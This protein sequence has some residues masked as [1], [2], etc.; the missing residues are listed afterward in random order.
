MIMRRAIIALGCLVA[1]AALQATPSAADTTKLVFGAPGIPPIF[2][3]SPVIIAD[4]AGFFAKFG[5]VEVRFF[6]NGA[7][8][9]RAVAA[10]DIDFSLSPAVLLAN[11]IS[12]SGVNLVGIYG[13]PNPDFLLGTTTAGKAN[14]RDV[15]GQPVGIDTPG[16]QRSLMLKEM[17][18]SCGVALDQV[19]QVSLGSNAAAAMIAGTLA[20]AVLHID[21]VSAIEAQGKKVTTI[22]TITKANPKAYNILGVA[23]LDRVAQDRPAFVGLIA[24]LMAATRYMKDPKNADKVAA[25]LATVNGRSQAENRKALAGYLAIDAWPSEADDDGMGRDKLDDMIENQVKIG[26][27]LPG[28]TPV[29]YDRLVD[30]SLW[31]DAAALLAKP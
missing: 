26:G 24:G 27:I 12:N 17:L 8:A 31:R 6:D 5:D 1:V 4:K 11:Q 28:K 14:C 7:A 19:Q 16:G 30:R 10:G 20:F 13:M 9:A 15:I 21:D 29:S 2:A 25:L 3:D 23:R 18:L 22:T